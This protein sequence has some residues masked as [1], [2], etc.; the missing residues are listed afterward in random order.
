MGLV[1]GVWE[2]VLGVVVF[3]CLFILQMGVIWLGGV[4][5]VGVILSDIKVRTK[6]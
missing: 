1:L 4:V 2:W 6:F 3:V 5:G